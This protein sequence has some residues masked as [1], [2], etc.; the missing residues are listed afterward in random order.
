MDIMRKSKLN[1]LWE[2][3]CFAFFFDY[4]FAIPKDIIHFEICELRSDNS[5]LVN[6]LTEKSRIREIEVLHSSLIV[7]T[8]LYFTS[9]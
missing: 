9:V 8:L 6:I 5:N 4:K 2:K 7:K 3:N 1:F